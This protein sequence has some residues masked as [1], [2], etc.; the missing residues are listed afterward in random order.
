MKFNKFMK[1]FALHIFL[2]VFALQP[3][4]QNTFYN[5]FDWGSY[6]VN[7]DDTVIFDSS[8]TYQQYG[9]DGFS[10]LFVK[11]WYPSETHTNSKS[12]KFRDLLVHRF[13][14][15]LNEVWK[16]YFAKSNDIILEDALTYDLING[17]TIDYKTVTRFDLFDSLMEIPTKSNYQA[18]SSNLQYPVIVYHHG[19]QG[20]AAENSVMAEYFASQGYIFIAANFHLPYEETTFGLRPFQLENKFQHN[21][22][23]AKRLISWA[24]KLNNNLPVIYIGHSW[25]AQEGWCFL[26]EKKQANV[27]ISLETTLE[28]KSDV[29]QIKNYWPLVYNALIEHQRKFE[30][31]TLALASIDD[32]LNF[33]VFKQQK[34][35]NLLFAA[36]KQPF[37]HNSYTSIYLMRYFLSPLI[38]NPDSEILRNQI[39][40]YTK[41]LSLIKSFIELGI[42]QTPINFNDFNEDFDFDF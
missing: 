7:Y 39:I 11:I 22:S 9:Y 28:Y 31:P 1:L 27:F 29:G 15:E 6:Q 21:Q 41:H 18:I 13:P 16:N 19:S 14:I 42:Y 38:A 26:H 5:Y 32:G 34:H 36:Y 25:G 35:T 3:K 4:C 17:E 33:S 37:A 30:I 8:K 24:K 20:N 23:E 10:P 2:L 12:L 40:G